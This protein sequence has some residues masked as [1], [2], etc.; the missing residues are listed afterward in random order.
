[1]KLMKIAL[2]CALSFTS[3]ARLQLPKDLILEQKIYQVSGYQCD[4]YSTSRTCIQ[5][6]AL[7][8]SEKESAN[9]RAD[10]CAFILPWEPGYNGNFYL[11]GACCDF[12]GIL[13]K[14]CYKVICKYSTNNGSTELSGCKKN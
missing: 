7:E 10:L 2:L 14:A 1:M 13:P 8:V 4:Q 5:T 9:S 11:Y 12:D 3:H 6:L